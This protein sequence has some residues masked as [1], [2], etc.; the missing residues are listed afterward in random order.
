MSTI[1][2]A[3]M[4]VLTGNGFAKDARGHP[5]TAPNGARGD[6]R[7]RGPLHNRWRPHWNDLNA[8]HGRAPV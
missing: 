3:A 6:K 4:S 8:G 1:G 7:P 2:T 5:V